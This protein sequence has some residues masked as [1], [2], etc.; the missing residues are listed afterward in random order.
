MIAG[1]LLGTLMLAAAAMLVGG[2][3]STTRLDAVD[4]PGGDDGTSEAT[5]PGA[6][7]SSGTPSA[8]ARPTRSVAPAIP[9][10]PTPSRMRTPTPTPTGSGQRSVPPQSTR[11][12][13]TPT[14]EPTADPSAGDTP[15]TDEPERTP[16]GQAKEPPG[17]GTDKTQGPKR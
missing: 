5:V 2:A 1:V 16:P 3:F 12:S 13:A 7:K 9:A 15:T 10:T 11:P 17:L 14:S 6:T 4:W 8:T